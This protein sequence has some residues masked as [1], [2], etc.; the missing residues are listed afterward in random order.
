MEKS[1]QRLTLP[2][3]RQAVQ[4]H[5]PQDE[6]KVLTEDPPNDTTEED[7]QMKMSYIHMHSPLISLFLSHTHTLCSSMPEIVHLTV[8]VFQLTFVNF[9]GGSSPDVPATVTAGCAPTKQKLCDIDKKSNGKR[10]KPVMATGKEDFEDPFDAVG[11]SSNTSSQ[12][13]LEQPLLSDTQF[14]GSYKQLTKGLIVHVQMCVCS[15]NI[16]LYRVL[17]THTHTHTHR[18]TPV[19]V[20]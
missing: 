20:N 15:C 13:G 18:H 7:G 4:Q 6:S 1:I 2:A 12:G 8:G 11:D 19:F 3:S 10:K 5:S 16:V 9:L 17:F 14:L